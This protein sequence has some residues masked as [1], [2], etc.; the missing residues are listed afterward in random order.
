M[1]V[2]TFTQF[3]NSA[4]C[5]VELLKDKDTKISDDGQLEVEDVD[6]DEWE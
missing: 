5:P 2:V 1:A 3:G 4:F 6:G